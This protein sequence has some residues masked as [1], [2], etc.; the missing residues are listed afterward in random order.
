WE[1]KLHLPARAQVAELT[2]LVQ[3]WLLEGNPTAGQVA[4]RV[5]I[6]WLLHALPRSHHQAVSMRNP[7]TTLKLVEAI[8]LVDAAQHQDKG[9]QVPPF[10]RRVVQEKR[11]LEGT[12]HPISRPAAPSP[13]DK[14]STEVPVPPAWNWLAGCIIHNNLPIRAPEVEL[15][16]NAKPFCA[17]LD[18]GSAASLVQPHILAPRGESKA[19]LPITCVHR[20]T[21]RVHARRVTTSATPRAWPVKVG[22]MKDLPVPV[23]L[24]RGRPGFD[25]LLAAATQPGSGGRCEDHVNAPTVYHPQTDGLVERFNQTL[26]QMLRRVVMEDK[27]DW[28]LMLPYILFGIRELP[29]ASTGFTPFELLFGR[30]PRGLLDRPQLNR[31]RRSAKG[32]PRQ[33]IGAQTVLTAFLAKMQIKHMLTV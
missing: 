5:V 20:D 9:E 8:K 16:I 10:P 24:G 1:Q 2:R 21:R 14:P 32:E 28:D 17:L 6:D 19:I 23:L 29:Q 26:K 25:C 4:E 30:Q 12:P 31:I 33:Y 18:S 27:R 11:T 7:S 13:R 3:H 15:K 22:L